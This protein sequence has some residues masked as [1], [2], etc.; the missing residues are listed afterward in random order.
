MSEEQSLKY[1]QLVSV[2][3]NAGWSRDEALNRAL[4]S[5]Q[6]RKHMEESVDLGA[7]WVHPK[8]TYGAYPKDSKP[9]LRSEM[10]DAEPRTLISVK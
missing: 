9:M 5:M 8:A 1:R 2:L 6:A 3:Q 4:M 10:P 7:F